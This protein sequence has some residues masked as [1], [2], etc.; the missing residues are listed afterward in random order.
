MGRY[1][2][3]EMTMNVDTNMEMNLKMNIQPP[4]SRVI[5]IRLIVLK[6]VMV[7]YLLS[8]L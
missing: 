4:L 5:L 7:L 2:A 3:D 6:A 8:K 1:A